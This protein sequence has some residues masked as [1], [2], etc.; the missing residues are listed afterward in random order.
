MEVKDLFEGCSVRI[1]D[2]VP[3]SVE[4]TQYPIDLDR[5]EAQI[6][7]QLH[8]CRIINS[9]V[10]A[11]GTYELVSPWVDVDELN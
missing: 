3:V 5:I 8:T 11:P 6:Q 4:I 1:E 7:L 9:P 2:D 10:H